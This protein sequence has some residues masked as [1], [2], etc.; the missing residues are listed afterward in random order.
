MLD[1]RARRQAA[2]GQTNG[3]DTHMQQVAVEDTARKT[4]VFKMKKLEVPI[5]RINGSGVF[6]WSVRAVTANGDRTRYSPQAY[7]N[8][9]PVGLLAEYVKASGED[10]PDMTL[11]VMLEVSV[12]SITMS[13][14]LPAVASTNAAESA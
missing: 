10:R 12:A 3:V 9:G 8:L 2:V 4:Q 14:P 6:L 11:A 7:F 5:D 13:A 1:V